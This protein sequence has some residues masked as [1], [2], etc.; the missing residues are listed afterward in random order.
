MVSANSELYYYSRSANQLLIESQDPKYYSN[1]ATGVGFFGAK[2]RVV[3]RI[4]MDSLTKVY[5]TKAL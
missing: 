1:M 4:E 2:S 3:K 5:L